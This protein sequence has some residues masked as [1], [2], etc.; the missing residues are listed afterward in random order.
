MGD[1][2]IVHC[3]IWALAFWVTLLLLLL[4]VVVVV[5]IRA[6]SQGSGCTAAIRL[7]VHPVFFLEVRTVAARCPHVLRDAIDPS[8]ER[9]NF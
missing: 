9:W 6:Q 8:S 3:I 4:V 2:D 5:V 1:D 7:I